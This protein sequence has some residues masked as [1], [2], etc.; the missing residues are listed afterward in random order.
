MSYTFR[1]AVRENVG[2]L[3]GLASP[4]GAGKTMSAMKLAKG[5]SGGKRF[6]MID[7]EARRS[8]HYA[9]QFDFDFIDLKPPF[10]PDAYTEAITAA[11]KAGYSAIITDSMSHEH[12]GEG[13]VLDWQEQELNELIK[14]AKERNDNRDEWKLRDAYNQLSWQKPKKAHKRMVDKF[15][16]CRSHL[17][18]CMRAEDK[19][20]FKKDGSGKTVVVPK[21]TLSGFKGWIPICDK[22]FLFELTTSFILLP[23]RPGVPIPI[24]LQ[25]Q[26]KA[27]FPEGK[28]ITEE[29]GAKLAAWAKGSGS[30]TSQGLGDASSSATQTEPG[31]KTG[32]TPEQG[33][34]LFRA[35]ENALP[36]G[37]RGGVR[38]LYA[39]WLGVNFLLDQGNPSA[40]AIPGTEFDKWK[41][42]A[43]KW[44][45]AK[46]AS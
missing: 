17:I 12:A 19:V 27:F 36:A 20:E 9:D 45:S 3:I 14:R 18:F 16:Q 4:S 11:E 10:T 5:I 7:T 38:E 42:E 13:G 2:L 46:R 21:E 29:A 30:A 25:E 40:S 33:K 34:E 6:A 39:T 26:H 1:P 24:K 8:L 31:K 28:P 23:D 37:L 41:A 35:F 32:I 15:L 44:A 22:R 43:V